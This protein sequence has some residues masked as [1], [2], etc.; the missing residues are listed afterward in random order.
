MSALPSAKA[1]RVVLA[2]DHPLYRLGLARSLRA[3]GIDVVAEAPNGEAALRA[4]EETAPDVV[5]M[6]LKMPGVSGLEAT[7]RLSAR[8]PDLPVLML[9]VSAEEVDVIDAMLAGAC[10]YVLK[11]QPVAEVIE[12][13][14]AAA[15]GGSHVSPELA[16]LLLRRLC[17]PAG[18]GVDAAGVQ[19][20]ARE[21]DV[22]G[23]LADGTT[24]HAVTEALSIDP[25]VLRAHASSILIKLHAEDRVQAGLRAYRRRHG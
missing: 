15:S 16:L 20:S 25:D 4:V 3:S 12:G 11:D 10:G 5:I 21:H 8:S 14:R 22:L 6:D 7:R 17:D 19:L 23:L 2:D 1:L 18:S 24:D 13:I 9:S